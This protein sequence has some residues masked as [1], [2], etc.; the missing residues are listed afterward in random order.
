MT[1]LQDANI[2]IVYNEDVFPPGAYFL[3]RALPLLIIPPLAVHAIYLAFSSH[4]PSSAVLRWLVYLLS[5]PL[6]EFVV[7]TFK[8]IGQA[9]EARRLGAIQVPMMQGRLPG[10]FDILATIQQN[11]RE[12]YCAESAESFG[13]EHG[14][15]FGVKILWSNNVSIHLSLHRQS[16]DGLWRILENCNHRTRGKNLDLRVSDLS[17]PTRECPTEHQKRPRDRLHQL[18]Q[19]CTLRRIVYDALF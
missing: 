7:R 2:K 17:V 16:G 9:Y 4:F 12:G 13:R 11:V 19:R 15:T 18:R 3:A 10:N 1:R 14:A 5:I 6:Y 8:S